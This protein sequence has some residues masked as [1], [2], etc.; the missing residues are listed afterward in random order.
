MIE[1][2]LLA[3]LA[4]LEVQFAA[5]SAT[6]ILAKPHSSIRSGTPTCNKEKPEVLPNKLEP[7][8]SRKK[9]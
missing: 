3:K 4:N 2:I 7:H 9:S 5:S 8:S 6:S 1:T